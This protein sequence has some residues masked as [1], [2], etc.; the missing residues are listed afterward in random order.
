MHPI[1]MRYKLE[2]YSFTVSEHPN[3]WADTELRRNEKL[4]LELTH[5]S[6]VINS[7]VE[8]TVVLDQ[9]GPRSMD[10]IQKIRLISRQPPISQKVVY[11]ESE[12]SIGICLQ[13]GQTCRKFELK[14]TRDHFNDVLLHFYQANIPIED[15][16]IADS[17]NSSPPSPEMDPS[18]GNDHEFLKDC[19]N[20][21]TK[22]KILELLKDDKFKTLIA[23]TDLVWRSLT[24]W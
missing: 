24:N 22:K 2:A 16:D 5:G 21:L 7:Y 3:L 23:E 15:G 1:P 12:K 4:S 19:E 20:S 11:V 13:A 9:N 18:P 10:E 17:H 14:L 8:L 6:N